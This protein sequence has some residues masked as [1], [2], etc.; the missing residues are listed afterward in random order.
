MSAPG[1]P[2]PRPW[3]GL[4]RRPAAPIGRWGTLGFLA[5]VLD[6]RACE[7]KWALPSRKPPVPTV[8][9]ESPEPEKQVELKSR[10]LNKDKGPGLLAAVPC[11]PLWSQTPRA[12]RRPAG[13]DSARACRG[14]RSGGRVRKLP[15]GLLPSSEPYLPLGSKPSGDSVKPQ[16]AA[17]SQKLLSPRICYSR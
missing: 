17:Q 4:L 2:F 9:P 14:W 5:L 10:R 8:Y 12:L 15:A 16:A 6:S 1:S 3:G 11:A 7:S 13:L